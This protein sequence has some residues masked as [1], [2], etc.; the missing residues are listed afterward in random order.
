MNPEE[1]YTAVQERTELKD[2]FVALQPLE[3]QFRTLE[4]QHEAGALG[5]WVFL[6]TEV[7]V[8]SAASSAAWRRTTSCTTTTRRRRAPTSTFGAA[9][10]RLGPTF[11]SCLAGVGAALLAVAVSFAVAYAPVGYEGEPTVPNMWQQSPDRPTV[12]PPAVER[13]PAR[14]EGASVR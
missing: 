10:L 6:A 13:P 3:E 12:P 1:S 14:P 11:R 4:D 7:M 8:S 2:T 5:M 9:C